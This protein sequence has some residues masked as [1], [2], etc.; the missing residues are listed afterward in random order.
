MRAARAQ[1]VAR[2]DARAWKDRY[3]EL[4]VITPAAARAEVEEVVPVDATT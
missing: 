4:V 3:P 2:L 1:S